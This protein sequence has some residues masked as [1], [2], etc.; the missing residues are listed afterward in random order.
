M[1]NVLFSAIKNGQILVK[2]TFGDIKG[3]DLPEIVLRVS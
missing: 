2:N 3:K 1:I